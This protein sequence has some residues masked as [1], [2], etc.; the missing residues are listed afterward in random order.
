MAEAIRLNSKTLEGQFF[1][2]LHKIYEAQNNLELNPE[3]YSFVTKVFDAEDLVLS[4]SFE[5]RV[6][7]NID[8]F[9]N[10]VYSPAPIL[11][12]SE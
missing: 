5:F 2:L 8:N 12:L 4:G 11:N 6:D 7:E 10:L 3:A 9:G 1:E